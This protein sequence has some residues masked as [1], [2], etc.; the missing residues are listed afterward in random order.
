MLLKDI[1]MSVDDVSINRT[2]CADSWMLCVYMKDKLLYPIPLDLFSY[3][4]EVQSIVDVRFGIT[5]NV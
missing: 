5:D 3:E 4:E 2:S 1:Y